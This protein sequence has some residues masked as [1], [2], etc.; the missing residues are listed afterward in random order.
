MGCLEAGKCWL[1]EDGTNRGEMDQHIYTYIHVYIYAR[2]SRGHSA[3]TGEATGNLDR[4]RI[5]ALRCVCAVPLGPGLCVM[6]VG[7]DG[8]MPTS[9]PACLNVT[10]SSSAVTETLGV[11]YVVFR[12][13]NKVRREQIQ[14]GHSRMGV[15]SIDC[16]RW[17]RRGA[18]LKR[19]VSY[20][21]EGRWKLSAA[22]SRS[23]RDNGRTPISQDADGRT[24]SLSRCDVCRCAPVREKKRE[25]REKRGKRADQSTEGKRQEKLS[26]VSQ[27][28]RC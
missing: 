6:G 11:L 23:T 19:E 12:G 3:E 7:E 22:R 25:K 8:W 28:V 21:D 15:S 10:F 5:S 14:S 1:G 27:P 13:N 4:H 24:G 26:P 9:W 17:A 20:S 16:P 18:K 2:P